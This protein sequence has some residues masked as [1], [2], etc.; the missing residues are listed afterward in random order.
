M[1]RFILRV[2]STF[3]EIE[4]SIPRSILKAA[5]FKIISQKRLLIFS[6][7]ALIIPY[8]PNKNVYISEIFIG[9]RRKLNA[10][11]AIYTKMAFFVEVRIMQIGI[12]HDANVSIEIVLTGSKVPRYSITKVSAV[13][14]PLSAIL[15]DFMILFTSFSLLAASY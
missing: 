6:I 10:L 4:Y 9:T 2:L 11:Q 7:K 12:K 13:I 15:L 5:N 3:I 1:D 8:I 14:I